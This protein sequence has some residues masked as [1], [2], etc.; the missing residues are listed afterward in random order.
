MRAPRSLY[1]WGIAQE[2]HDLIL[3]L[4][5][6]SFSAPYHVAEGDRDP[7]IGVEVWALPK[8]AMEFFCRLRRS[9]AGTQGRSWPRSQRTSAGWAPRWRSSWGRIRL[10]AVIGDD[11]AGPLLLDQLAQ[12][13]PEEGHIGD[14]HL[15][16]CRQTG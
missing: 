4:L 10:I 16:R 9:G 12:I 7:V 2:V 8:L 13:L 11:A 14:P 6:L 1:F 5:L 15:S 3:Q